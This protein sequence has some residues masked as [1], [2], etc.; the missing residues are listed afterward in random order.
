MT[1]AQ[2]RQALLAYLQTAEAMAE[3]EA[4]LFSPAP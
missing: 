4:V 2:R 1:A 3:F